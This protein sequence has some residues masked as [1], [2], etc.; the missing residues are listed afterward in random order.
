[1]D[2]FIKRAVPSGSTA[3][4]PPAKRPTPAAK[5]G[6][7]T[8]AQRALEFG[9]A[10]FYADGGKLFCRS[11]NIV[12]DHFRKNTV[13]KHVNSK[14]HVEK[15]LKKPTVDENRNL[16]IQTLKTV[17]NARTDAEYAR[18]ELAIDLS[19]ALLAANIPLE[20]LD[21][22]AIR[23]FLEDKVPGSGSIPQAS[24]VRRWYLPT[25]MLLYRRAI[26]V[27]YWQRLLTP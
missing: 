2:R 3:S 20:K 1:M 13:D 15:A 4:S 25:V 27:S 17:V 24:S 9:K 5:Q 23:R 11:C 19:E 12:V 22:P 21:H 6:K 18:K 7:V 14:K 16:R 8:A 26:S 10:N